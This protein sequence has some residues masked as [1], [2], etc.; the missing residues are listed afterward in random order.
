MTDARSQMV[1]FS[2]CSSFFIF[3]IIFRDL[4]LVSLIFIY[5]DLKQ[6]LEIQFHV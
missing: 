6:N 1:C 2:S 3:E 4:Q 5:T